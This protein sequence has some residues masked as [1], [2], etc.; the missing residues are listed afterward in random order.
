MTGRYCCC[1]VYPKN[2]LHSYHGFVFCF[3]TAT[4][5]IYGSLWLAKFNLKCKMQNGNAICKM[6]MYLNLPFS[7][8][9]QYLE[10][11]EN[12]II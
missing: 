5:F 8:R 4:V 12:V 11:N 10:Q 6:G 3:I 7:T 2:P 1:I 9:V